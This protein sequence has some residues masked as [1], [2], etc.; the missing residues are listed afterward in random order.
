MKKLRDVAANKKR[1]SKQTVGCTVIDPEKWEAI[2]E[3]EREL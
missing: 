1:R 3:G 2:Q